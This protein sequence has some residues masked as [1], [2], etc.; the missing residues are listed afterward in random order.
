LWG[1][2]PRLFG[3]GECAALYADKIGRPSVPPSELALVVLMQHETGVA[4]TE[5]VER[6]GVDLRWASVPRRGAGEPLCAKSTLQLFRNQLVL[7][8]MLR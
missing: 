7:H 5:A 4:D 8:G 2:A 3:D 6:T 1:A